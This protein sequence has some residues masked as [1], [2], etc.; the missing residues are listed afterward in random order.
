MHPKRPRLR[1]VEAFAVDTEQGMSLALRDPEGLGRGVLLV[2]RPLLPLLALLDGERTVDDLARELGGPGDA[3]LRARIVETLETLDKNF[4]LEGPRVDREREKIAREYAQAPVRP[5]IHAGAAYSAEAGALAAELES[6]Y[7]EPEGPGL[8]APA[9]KKPLRALIAPHIDY[10]RG[11][12]CYAWGYRELRAQQG[13]DV[14]FVLGT[15]HAGLQS[16]FAATLKPYGTP[17]GPAET[18]AAL[19]KSLAKRAKLDLLAEEPAHRVEHSIELQA[20]FLKHST[21]AERPFK[22]VPVLASYCHELLACGL[23]PRG[24]DAVRRFVDALR[25]ELARPGR[26]ACL[27][28]GADLAHMGTRFGDAALTP[29][30]MKRCETEDR[31]LLATACAV[32]PDAFF[33]RIK[34]EGDRRRVCGFSPIHAALAALEGTGAKGELLRYGYYPD[35]EG[36]V[37]YAS[38]S[39]R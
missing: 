35:P 28:V 34:A 21:P 15:C 32:D 33:A 20:V 10:R 22:I 23:D 4:M 9:R 13:A 36:L 1:E 8:R 14:Y 16:P 5:A 39:F 11:G 7:K 17:F 38:V 2:P 29:E 6:Y 37:S 31:A 30:D 19:V 24:D 27:I 18:D 26:S 12:P 3:A 25:E